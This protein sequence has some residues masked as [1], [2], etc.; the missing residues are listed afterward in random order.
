[1]ITVHNYKA[2]SPYGINCM[3]YI[4]HNKYRIPQGELVRLKSQG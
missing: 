3:E 4:T 2:D 1:M